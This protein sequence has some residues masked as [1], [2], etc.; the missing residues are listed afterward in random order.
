MK[1]KRN[2]ILIF[3]Y[4]PLLFCK[5]TKIGSKYRNAHYALEAYFANG[6]VGIG[7]YIRYLKAET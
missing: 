6:K 2:K 1:Q 5:N 3:T 4:T 7:K